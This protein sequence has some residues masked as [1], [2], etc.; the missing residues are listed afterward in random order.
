MAEL[1]SK[2]EC[3]GCGAK[4]YD[5]GRSEIIC[6]KCGANQ[7]EPDKETAAKQASKSVPKASA[8]ASDLKVEVSPKLKEE[9]DGVGADGDDD[10]KDQK[11]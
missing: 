10:E 8:V 2:H 7:K 5:L 11:A 9:K 3:L 4:F 6:P 1:G